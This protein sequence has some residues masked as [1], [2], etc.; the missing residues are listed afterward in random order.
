MNVDN[1]NLKYELKSKPFGKPSSPKHIMR[2]EQYCISIKKAYSEID[3][4]HKVM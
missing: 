1:Q 2:I 4:L 3:I